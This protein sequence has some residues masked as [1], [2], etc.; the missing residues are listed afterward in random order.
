MA[1]HTYKPLRF[2]VYAFL[3]SWAPWI[4][5]AYLSYLPTLATYQH[6]LLIL[7]V[8]GPCISAILM[9]RTSRDLRQDFLERLRINKIRPRFVPIFLFL[10]LFVILLATL[11]SVLFGLP[12][13]QFA[14]S[15]ACPILMGHGILSLCIMVLASTFEE[16]GWRGYGVDS[17]KSRYNVLNTSLIF[18][19]L[20]ALWHVPL[21][22]VNGYYHHDL[23]KAHIGY[24]ANFFAN[25][26]AGAILINWIYFKNRRSIL[27]AIFFHLSLNISYTIFQ[28]EPLTK[29]IATIIMLLIC[30][31]L[32]WNDRKFF[33]E[34]S[35]PS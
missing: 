28:T 29:C 32:I 10:A 2:F 25:V 26:V 7:G 11:I 18:G 1:Q 9:L 20:W 4:T 8:F 15:P 34:K 22:F 31:F 3:F 13:H 21:F 30:G 19:I 14:F 33:L 17:L 35:T 12:L 6:I 23:W 27:V 24:V 5:A 16:F